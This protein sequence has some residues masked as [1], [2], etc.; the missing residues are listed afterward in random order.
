MFNQWY[1]KS[2]FSFKVVPIYV[3]N[4][5]KMRCIKCNRTGFLREGFKIKYTIKSEAK[6]S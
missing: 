6:R 3:F 2:G 5:K 4:T 1:D